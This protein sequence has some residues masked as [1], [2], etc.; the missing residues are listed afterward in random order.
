MLAVCSVHG[1]AVAAAGWSFE[2]SLGTGAYSHTAT[3]LPNGK[4]LVAGGGGAG[5][6]LNRAELFDPSN[7]AWTPTGQLGKGRI[8]HTTTLLPNGKVLVAGGLDAS[9]ILR[10]AELYDPSTGTW[11]A[12]GDLGGSR[13][14]HTA[15]LLPNGKVLVTGGVASLL[16]NG[17]TPASELYDPATGLWASTGSLKIGRSR[18]TATLLPNG[19]VLLVGGS[20]FTFETVDC[21]PV[22]LASAEIYDPATGAWASTGS[23]N[24]AR[25]D[26]TAT[27]LPNGKV[28]VAGAHSS[29]ELYDP[30]TGTWTPTGSVSTTRGVHTATLLPSGKVLIAGGSG[31][32]GRLSSAELY[33]PLTGAWLPTS[34]LSEG[35]SAHTAVL[36]PHGKVLITGGVGGA[37]DAALTSTE[38]YDSAIGSWANTGGLATRRANH[39][40]TLLPSGKLL[41][42]GGFNRPS[43]SL[44]TQSSS[45]LYDHASAT[46]SSTGSLNSARHSH[47]ATL[48]ASGKV[49]VAGGLG[50]SSAELYDPGAGTW[51]VT[52]NLGVVRARHTATLLGN[53]NVLVAGGVDN[54]IALASAEIYDPQTGSWTPTSGNLGAARSD[55]TA[56]LM[57]D[58][59]VLIAAGRSGVTALASAAIYDPASGSWTPIENL[60]AARSDHSSTLLAD[61]GV[62]IAGGFNGSTSLS[63]GEIYYSGVGWIGAA[64]LVTAANLHTATTLLDGTVIF[65]G[66][67]NGAA[68]NPTALSSATSFDP[69][70][71]S[72]PTASLAA[73]R[74]I[75]TATLLPNGK[76]LV[77]GG[78][79]GN[80]YL[81]SAELYDP[82]LGFTDPQWRPALTRVS[83]P[84]APG[85]PVTATGSFFRGIGEATGGGTDS[86]SSNHPVMQLRRLDNEQIITLLTNP[87]G[88][89]NTTFSGALPQ[90][91]NPGPA[92]VTIFTNG[93]PSLARSTVVKVAAL[94]PTSQSF[95]AAGDSSAFM[96]TLPLTTVWNAVAGDP[97]IHITSPA[98]GTGP[99]T[100]S[101]SVDPHASL[102]PR[103]ST[104]TVAG[105]T[106]TVRQGAQFGDV[107]QADLFYGFI[108]RLSG[109]GV[110]QG[111]SVGLY[112]P[113]AAVTRAQMAVF[114][115][116][117]KRGGTF[118]PPPATCVDGH[119]NNFT[120]VPCPDFFADYIEQLSADGVTVGC[121][122][123]SYC[124]N[125]PVTRAQMA[126]FIERNLGNF[127]PPLAL[128]QR[129]ADV[130]MTHFAH[131]FVEDLA[132]RSITLGCETALY[133][134]AQPVT[135]AQ[136]AAFLIRAFAL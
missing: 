110:T 55:H 129:F 76:L 17:R 77:A 28:L 69:Q 134:P 10:S 131:P 108:G 135:R 81:N 112:C 22:L 128:A 130:P 101:F 57:R 83:S 132:A 87:G 119:T 53:G 116:R 126:I 26:A 88:W 121:V 32:G 38:S 66:G 109:G 27:L 15:T 23:L 30:S 31:S 13:S 20:G 63:S 95:A 80:L 82:G 19:R 9:G 103:S 86:S 105:E 123:M 102:T 37:S 51:T 6:A 74:F 35:R 8:S 24:V 54:S 11:T 70:V 29:T 50:R 33:D 99:A 47:T 25:G 68:A 2:G 133:C 79:D 34:N 44:Q 73:A 49:L 36:L 97:W 40:A 94:S 98:I 16:F 5:S 117:A 67:A 136:M 90:G 59:R 120:D 93:I 71:G 118:V 3:L 89:S 58:G 46:W 72:Q 85:G 56:T 45:E 7:G 106:F 91:F 65:A 78:F 41:V 1:S 124:P 113:N 127:I 104:I 125:D 62:L 84:V 96:L 39:T 75:H 14:D 4:V 18:A 92:V 107:P 111:C 100:V 42:A 21:C 43:V 61:G 12:T 114:L 64:G 52:G 122:A 115:Q 48:L 60:A